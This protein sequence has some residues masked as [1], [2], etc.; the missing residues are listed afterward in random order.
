MKST[1]AA[2][3]LTNS[4]QTDTPPDHTPT[5][6]PE[7]SDSDPME[8]GPSDPY[9]SASEDPPLSDPLENQTNVASEEAPPPPVVNGN[10]NLSSHD[11]NSNVQKFVAT[12]SPYV[13]RILADMP[14]LVQ[15]PTDEE[16]SHDDRGEDWERR[17]AWR[18]EKTQE[19]KE[20]M[21]KA[22]A[23]LSEPQ[24]QDTHIEKEN[25]LTTDSQEQ[26]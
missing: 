5:Q 11:D 6:Q 22:Q 25:E 9:L 10:S 7:L 1:S 19:L 2:A 12:N 4:A 16:L 17:R 3:V 13:A 23:M 15:P 18:E 8:S 20:E 14:P 24:Q 21:E 26:N